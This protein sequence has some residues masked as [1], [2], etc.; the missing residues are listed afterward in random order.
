[1]TAIKTLEDVSG[2]QVVSYRAPAFSITHENPP[3]VGAGPVPARTAIR[4]Y[5]NAKTQTIRH[6]AIRTN[7]VYTVTL[8]SLISQIM[9]FK[10]IME[11]KRGVR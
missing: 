9:R 3:T 11:E 7:T 5:V 1:M 8:I 4:R 10:E 2:Q 6:L